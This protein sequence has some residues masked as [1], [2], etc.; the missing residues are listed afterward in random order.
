MGNQSSEVKSQ[1]TGRDGMPLKT[2]FSSGIQPPVYKDHHTQGP[3]KVGKK[4]S[5]VSRQCCPLR[6]VNM[7]GINVDQKKLIYRKNLELVVP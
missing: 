7:S 6:A 4:C 5:L 2:T 1:Y 3:L